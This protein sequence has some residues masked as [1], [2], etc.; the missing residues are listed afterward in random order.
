MDGMKRPPFV[1]SRGVWHRVLS[2]LVVEGSPGAR[3]YGV[4]IPVET[5][6]AYDEVLYST[7]KHGEGAAYD[8]GV[9]LKEAKSSALLTAYERILPWE[10]RRRHF[11][12]VGGDFCFE[13]L[14]EEPAI[15]AFADPDEAHAWRPD[16]DAIAAGSGGER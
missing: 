3:A 13:V 6:A 10:A 16:F 11:L 1:V 2:L 12:F 4:Q 9:Y 14:G 7:A 5:Y 8:G 15:H